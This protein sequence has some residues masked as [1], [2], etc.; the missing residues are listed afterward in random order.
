LEKASM[1]RNDD[2]SEAEERAVRNKI[3]AVHEA[4]ER[5]VEVRAEEFAKG[6]FNRAENRLKSTMSMFEDGSNDPDDIMESADRAKDAFRDAADEARPKFQEE[7]KKMQP[8]ERRSSLR[9]EA[10]STFGNPYV[11]DEPKG[12]RI[13]LARLFEAGS[14]AVRMSAERQVEEVAKL[15][16]EYEEADIQIEGY[17]RKG[18]ATENLATSQVRAKEV[19]DMLES[20]GVDKNR[21]GTSGKGQERVRYQD[22]PDKNDR[23]EVIFRIPD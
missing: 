22:D 18:D 17:T 9:E 1:D 14:S 16:E 2:T 6:A 13:I 10:S 21:I 4:K 3:D 20:H 19:A 8:V 12:A 23:V 7:E 15:A 5:A 11:K